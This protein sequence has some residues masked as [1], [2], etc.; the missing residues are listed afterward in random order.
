MSNTDD[1]LSTSG[2]TIVLVFKLVADEVT[3]LP[4]QV[5]RAL[6]TKDFQQ[7]VKKALESEAQLLL[8]NQPL[9]THVVVT[10]PK[11]ARAMIG[12]I[13][14]KALNP[15]KNDLIK[16]IENT[17]KAQ[18][19]KSNVKNIG[20][21][22]KTSKLG[23]WIDQNKMVLYIVGAVT[24]IGGAAALYY[25]KSGDFVGNFVKG[26]AKTIN[27]GSIIIKG[28]LTQFQPSTRTVGAAIDA[29]ANLK[30]VKVNLKIAGLAIGDTGQMTTEGNIVLP[31]AT[32]LTLNTT[33]KYRLGDLSANPAYRQLKIGKKDQYKYSLAVGL[34]YKKDKFNAVLLT[35]I[36]DDK[37][38]TKF[39]L[40]NTGQATHFAYQWKLQVSGDPKK[41][42][43]SG[44]LNLVGKGKL[45][46][47]ALGIQGQT[48]TTGEVKVLGKLT[49]LEFN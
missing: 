39:A 30:P 6:Q 24:A 7:A 27:L 48:D 32:G 25:F 36:E 26:K 3:D 21:Q 16:Q 23:V 11:L 45:S 49:I 8:K 22:V 35:R 5:A 9:A 33:G 18:K 1:I 31:V 43:C 2:E 29:Q 40:Q 15:V 19:I 38:T 47:F 28:T 13:A 46:P 14:E 17:D 4:S 20:A 10:D 41:V 34:E 37:L 12:R 44:S 42:T